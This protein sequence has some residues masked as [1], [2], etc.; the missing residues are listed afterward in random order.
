MN[1]Q[2]L[3]RKSFGD[4][5][6]LAMVLL[7]EEQTKDVIESIKENGANKSMETVI[8]RITEEKLKEMYST[9]ESL[10]PQLNNDTT[11]EQFINRFQRIK[12]AKPP[13]GFASVEP[14]LDEAILLALDIHDPQKETTDADED[15]FQEFSLQ[16]KRL[17]DVSLATMKRNPI[18]K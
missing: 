14:I 8:N 6:T 16:I 3:I 18:I 1:W 17:A 5:R 4:F 12:E 10:L 2:L 15:K 7:S 11:L 9:Y 13:Q